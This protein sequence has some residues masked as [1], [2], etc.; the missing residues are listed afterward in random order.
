[1]PVTIRHRLS[2]SANLARPRDGPSDEYH[3]TPADYRT[4]PCDAWLAAYLLSLAVQGHLDSRLLASEWAAVAPESS[5]SVE[6]PSRPHRRTALA[7]PITGRL[8]CSRRSVFPDGTIS[9]ITLADVLAS[10]LACRYLTA[11]H[12]WGDLMQGW[13]PIALKLAGSVLRAATTAVVRSSLAPKPGIGVTSNPAPTRLRNRLLSPKEISDKDIRAFS[14]HVLKLTQSLQDTEFRELPENEITATLELVSSTISRATVDIFECDL[15]PTLYAEQV[16]AQ[17]RN[18]ITGALLSEAAEQFY[19]RLTYEVSAQ[20]VHFATTWPAFLA[21]INAEQLKR[22][23]RMAKDL[24][25]IRESA[26]DAATQMETRFEERYCALIIEKLDHLELFG[27][28]L[29]NAEAKAYSLSTAYISLALAEA[30]GAAH[31][32]HHSSP[33]DKMS[34]VSAEIQKDPALRQ[35]EYFEQSVG[36]MRSETAL[37]AFQRILLR[38]EAGSGKTTLLFWLAVNAAR[39]SLDGALSSLNGYIP[40]MLPLRRFAAGDLPS[41]TEFLREV[42]RHLAGEM[43]H[44]WVNRVLRSGRALVLVD[45]VDELPED[46]RDEART[47]L[48]DLLSTYP[49][50]RYIVTSRP[51]AAEESWLGQDGFASLDLLP[52]GRADIENFVKH[53]HEAAE[54]CLPIGAQEADFEDLETYQEELINAIGNQRQLRRLASNPLLCAL[55]CTLN[56]DRR[57]QLPKGRMELYAA[58]LEM[59]L[60]RRDVER[61]INHP[62]A[63]SLTLQQKKRMLGHLAYWLL[64]NEF[65]DCTETQATAQFGAALASMPTVQTTGEQAFRYLLVRSGVLREPVDGRVDF[66]HRTFQEYLAAEH[67]IALGDHLGVL[68]SHAHLDQWHEVATMAVGHARPNERGEILDKLITRG[69]KESEHLTRLHLL[70][71]ACLESADELDP[72]TYA[73]VQAC[74]AALIPPKRL[75]EAKELAAAGEAVL[76]LLPRGNRRVLVSEAAATVRTAAIIGGESALEILSSYGNDS[77]VAVYKELAR[78]WSQFDVREYALKVM[79]KSPH[80]TSLVLDN[81]DILTTLDLFPNLRRLVVRFAMDSLEWLN[82]VP[83]LVVARLVISDSETDL[84]PLAT[85]SSLRELRLVAYDGAHRNLGP[86]RELDALSVL[87]VASPGSRDSQGGGVSLANIPPHSNLSHLALLHCGSAP[88]EGGSRLPNLQTLMLVPGRMVDFSGVENF[89]GIRSLRLRGIEAYENEDKIESLTSLR[90]VSVMAMN[91]FQSLINALAKLPQLKELEIQCLTDA[92]DSIDLNPFR[93]SS[94]LSITI[95]A[96]RHVAIFQDSSDAAKVVIHRFDL[97]E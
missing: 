11:R 94:G 91:P 84:S 77:R 68:I 17:S 30:E 12:P 74:A 66:V 81:P 43:P 65:S 55:L 23:N 36:S 37:A 61:K 10:P 8:W 42:G 32:I 76:S 69:Q 87:E 58:A 97:D 4:A 27:I 71:A 53:W 18:A 75:S 59:L 83:G 41:P 5:L 39:R 28:T 3:W 62:E 44:Q 70:A 31:K 46:R 40:F 79:S 82:R 48:R 50:A 73:R 2:A 60:V 25:L 85:Q 7:T 15:E 38:G 33:R 29:A 47:W 19:Y 64:R 95:F 89:A 16:V 63:P 72:A 57:M 13:E 45:G 34:S 9:G 80:V 92:V 56:R 78:A 1:M 67:L 51:A 21:T 93:G 35:D 22:I 96:S 6:N 14:D 86:L 26:I 88:F 54:E 20:V 49:Q 24:N 90:T 52:M